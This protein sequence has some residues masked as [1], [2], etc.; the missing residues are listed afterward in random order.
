MAKVILGPTIGQASG[1]L[2]SMIFSHNRGGAYLRNGSHPVISTT[3]DAL[4]A[5]ARLGTVSQQWQAQTTGVRK[6]WDEFAK[7]NPVND[8]LRQSITLTGHASFV[9][10]NTRRL[11][12]GLAL[13]TAPPIDPAPQAL[14]TLAL[15]ADIGTGDFEI[16]FTPTPLGATELLWIRAAV[17]EAP[18]INYVENLLRVVDITSA[19]ETSPYDPQAAIEAKFGT[20]V[21]GMTVTV[22]VAV[23][24]NASGLIS[25][26]LRASAVVIS[27]P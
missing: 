9:K 14:T 6:S 20:L 13:L 23:Y 26:E 7:N 2:G 16:N 3:S 12:A 18:S 10:L 27:S 1:R 8:R 5:K 25:N 24:D 22:Q 19:A 21:V 4:A 17:T 11:L 15:E